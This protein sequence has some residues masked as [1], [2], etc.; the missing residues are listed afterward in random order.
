MMPS[1]ETVIAFLFDLQGADYIG[2]WSRKRLNW[3]N[4]GN[5]D[6]L[7]ATA[8]IEFMVTQGDDYIDGEAGANSLYGG[9]GNDCCFGGNEYDLIAR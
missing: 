8:K 5:D 6:L 9:A 3:G 4:S 7:V 1:K 2:R